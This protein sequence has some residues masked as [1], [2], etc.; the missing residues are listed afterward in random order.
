MERL[1]AGSPEDL[2]TTLNGRYVVSSTE[3]RLYAD[4]S[5]RA[6]LLEVTSDE[7][8]GQLPYF[9]PLFFVPGRK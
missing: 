6:G 8:T 4:V 9:A 1:D 7:Q 3:D 2:S 5:P